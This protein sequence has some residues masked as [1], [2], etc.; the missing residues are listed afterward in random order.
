MWSSCSG[1]G[2]VVSEPMPLPRNRRY[3]PGICRLP[4]DVQF[5]AK[6]NSDGEPGIS[7]YDHCMNVGEV[8]KALV[9]MASPCVKGLAPPFTAVLAALHDVGKISPG[10]QA[11]SEKWLLRYDLVQLAQSEAW[12][13]SEGDHAKI[14]QYTLQGLWEDERLLR[15]AAALGAHHGCLKG[16]RV[17]CPG[18]WSEY[19]NELYRQLEARFGKL[20]DKGPESDAQL[21]WLAGL[22]TFADWIGSDERFFP[23]DR[24]LGDQE[25]QERAKAALER[26]GWAYKP[27]KKNLGFEQLFPGFQPNALQKTVLE[28]VCE[29]G[30]YVIEAPMGQGKTE[31]ALAAAYKLLEAEMASGI[32]FALPTQLT[33]NRIYLRVQ[34]F[35][36]RIHEH[37]GHVRLA[38]SASWL[39]DPTAPPTLPR[40]GPAAE[41]DTP[42]EDLA[43]SWFASPK[44]ALLEACGVG[45]VDQALLGVISVKHFFLRQFGLAGKVV[46]LDEVHSYDVYTG[47]LITQLVRQL[48]DNKATVIILSATLTCDRRRELL[49][50]AVEEPAEGAYP[51]VSCLRQTLRQYPCPAPPRKVVQVRWRE[52]ESLAKECLGQAERGYC[53]LWI[54]NTVARAQEVY[55]NLKS[56]ARE[57]GPML[58]L[59]HS[60]FPLSEREKREEHWMKALG[61]EGPRPGGCIL[62]ATQVVEQSVDVDADLL[63]TDLAPI[64]MLLQRMGR[65][66]RHER[67]SRPA[68][69]P[70]VWIETPCHP[71]IFEHGTSEEIR[72]ALGPGARVY[73]PYILLRTYKVLQGKGSLSVPDEIREIL[74]GTYSEPENGEP[75]GWEA[76]FRELQSQRDKLQRLA[77][78]ASSIWDR[79]ALDDEEVQ[80]RYS[81]VAMG[82]LLPVKKFIDG[83]R[84]DEVEL[85]S[86]QVIGMDA[87]SWDFETA[88]AVHRHLIRAPWHA[89]REGA[90][91]A[92]PSLK[93][94]ADRAAVAIHDADGKLIWHHNGEFSGLTYHNELGLCIAQNQTRREPREEDWYESC[95]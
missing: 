80:T 74:E 19:R 69:Q 21:W 17:R 4:P 13:Q 90:C 85:M 9:D 57:G 78:N 46:I 22:V 81:S 94:Y 60:R 39:T 29:P 65:L 1:Q 72:S 59:L 48:R 31:A 75:S 56:L 33:S 28:T 2:V 15:W 73:A 49:G 82:H 36:R 68:T 95:F 11:K 63:I 25:R 24:G 20:P 38:H 8:A 70:E 54:C 18:H 10:F 50:Q 87:R 40:S 37:P 23:C 12:A 61:R 52:A 41:G 76:L 16:L 67:K 93:R 44:R 14:T 84:S 43:R 32:Y 86:G 6:T 42:A 3:P 55:R 62:V 34:Q 26:I 91:N 47:S 5:W 77:W 27:V 7:V 64:D 35:I 30:I 92:P 58:G 89:L 45:T 66:W 53:V 51:L 88:K 71:S 83:G 79:P